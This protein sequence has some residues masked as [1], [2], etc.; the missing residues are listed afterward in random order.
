[1]ALCQNGKNNFSFNSAC[2][3]NRQATHYEWLL[4]LKKD[5]VWCPFLVK[6][7]FVYDVADLGD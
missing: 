5:T 1:M 2:S 3:A 6:Y 7:Y 4:N